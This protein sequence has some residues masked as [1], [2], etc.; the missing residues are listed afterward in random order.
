MF[1]NFGG[2]SDYFIL[3]QT[4]MCFF[5]TC[6]RRDQADFFSSQNYGKLSPFFFCQRF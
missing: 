6:P 3:K 5:S 1:E 4:F 2:I